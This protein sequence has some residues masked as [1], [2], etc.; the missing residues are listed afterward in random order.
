MD[1]TK[2]CWIIRFTDGTLASYYGAKDGAIAKAEGLKDLYG[3]EITSL[4]KNSSRTG[5]REPGFRRLDINLYILY[6]L[7]G[8]KSRETERKLL[9]F[10]GAKSLFTT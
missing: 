1:N 6:H 2:I 8:E 4:H 9:F 10:Y 7:R 5:I 3:G